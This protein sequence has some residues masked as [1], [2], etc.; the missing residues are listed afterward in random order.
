[1]EGDRRVL[2]PVGFVP[3]EAK[4][5]APA[6]PRG[7]ARRGRV[8]DRLLESA[9]SPV[10]LVTAPPGYGKTLAVGRWADEDERDHTRHAR[11]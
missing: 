1:M 8:V 7:L 3:L 4:L 9:D 5:R 11:E 10:V 6:L 2:R